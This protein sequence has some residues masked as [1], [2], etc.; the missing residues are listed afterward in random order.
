MCWGYG[1]DDCIY[2]LDIFHAK[3]ES[4]ELRREAYAFYKKHNTPRKKVTDAVLRA[5]YIEDKSSGSGLIQEL[6]RKQVKVKDLQRNVDKVF[7]ADDAIPEIEA[8]RVYLNEDVPYVSVLTEEA[9]QFPNGTH[10]DVIDPCMSAIE[11]ALI[12][13]TV[14][15]SLMAAMEA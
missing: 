1:I 4:P 6:K 3:L 7:R 13:K 2:L 12:N 14:G 5:F 9:R 15:S 11:V 10:D 8:G